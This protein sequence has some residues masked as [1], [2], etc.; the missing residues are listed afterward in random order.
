MEVNHI[1]IL[2]LTRLFFLF[3]VMFLGVVFMIVP[4]SPAQD[5]FPFADMKVTPE[6]YTYYVVEHVIIIIFSLHFYI[7][8]TDDK[9]IILLFLILQIIDLVDFMLTYN[10]T[11]FLYHGHPIT[12]NIIKVLVFGL[13]LSYEFIKRFAAS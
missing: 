10:M 11:W 8:A 5:F 12:F 6:W 4:D 2:Y 1:T 7:E 3:S 9:K 13:A